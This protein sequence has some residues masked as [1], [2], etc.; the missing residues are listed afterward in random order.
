MTDVSDINI[1]TQGDGAVETE[2]DDSK[3]APKPPAPVDAESDAIN[4][5]GMAYAVAGNFAFSL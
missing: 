5:K 1:E 4:M 3:A 2:I